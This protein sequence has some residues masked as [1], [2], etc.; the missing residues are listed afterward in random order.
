MVKRSVITPISM[1]GCPGWSKSSLDANMNCNSLFE[2]HISNTIKYTNIQQNKTYL[3][4]SP[5]GLT[6]HY[7]LQHGILQSLSQ[8]EHYV[9]KRSVSLRSL[10]SHF[11]NKTLNGI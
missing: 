7:R 6:R 5:F 2:C 1:Y 9:H 3:I 10:S 4:P 11:F 8:F